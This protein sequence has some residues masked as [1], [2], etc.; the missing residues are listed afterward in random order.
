MICLLAGNAGVESLAATRV[1]ARYNLKIK[2][3]DRWL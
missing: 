3:L 1:Y 2:Y